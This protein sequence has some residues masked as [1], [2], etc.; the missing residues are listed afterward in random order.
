VLRKQKMLSF[1][2]TLIRN[3]SVQYCFMPQSLFGAV[4]ISC[5]CRTQE[6]HTLFW[7]SLAKVIPSW[8][9]CV[10]LPNYPFTTP[11]LP[12][13][14]KFYVHLFQSYLSAHSTVLF[15]LDGI[16]WNAIVVFIS[17][18]ILVTCFVCIYVFSSDSNLHLGSK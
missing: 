4:K 8:L 15:V 1:V 14:I 9:G 7:A 16:M 17:V 13:P 5:R 6:V 12:V 11:K 18:T 3:F 10:L 2:W